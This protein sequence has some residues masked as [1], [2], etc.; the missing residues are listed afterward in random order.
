M[1]SQYRSPFRF[2]GFTLIE[3]LVVISVVALLMGLL[4]PALHA[5]RQQGHRTVCL[6]NLRQ[7]SLAAATYATAYDDFYPLAYHNEQVGNVRYFHAWDFTTWRD[8]SGGKPVDHVEPGILWMGQTNKKIQQCPVFKGSANWF[9]DPFTGYNYNT[10]YIGLNE[11]NRPVT[12]TKTF[13]VRSPSRTALFGDGEYIG[14][15]NKF[16]RA[17]LSNP[18]DASFSDGFRHAGVQGFRHKKTTNVAFCDGHAESLREVYTETNQASQS[19]LEEHNQTH[20]Y[21]IGFLSE[22]NRLYDLD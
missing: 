7:L 1:S 12:A 5:A 11:T 17:P 22:D 18:R 2:S 16:M 3:L 10:S 14:G 4:V 13:E 15:A 8:W 20:D 9:E 19:I 6:N 21:P